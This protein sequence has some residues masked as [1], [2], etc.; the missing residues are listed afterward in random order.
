MQQKPLGRQ[1]VLEKA[2]ADKGGCWACLQKQQGVPL[3]KSIE[4]TGYCK[5]G[6]SAEKQSSARP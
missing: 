3:I 4:K 5:K 2:F 1:V 6:Q